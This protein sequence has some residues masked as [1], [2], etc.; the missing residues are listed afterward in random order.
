M[1]VMHEYVCTSH[2]RSGEVVTGEARIFLEDG[3][4][5]TT[6]R[7]G[8]FPQEQNVIRLYHADLVS[9]GSNYFIATEIKILTKD[10]NTRLWSTS[11]KLKHKSLH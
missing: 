1:F 9:D 6:P 2:D 5:G 10:V 4:L 3:T 11:R 7:G 8:S